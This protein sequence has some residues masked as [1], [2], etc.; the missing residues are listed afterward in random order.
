MR[1]RNLDSN[2]DWTFGKGN[3]N[4]AINKDAVKLNVKTRL[5]EWLND[6]FFAQ[7]KG[8]DY[9]NRLGDKGQE[10][11][12]EQDIRTIIVQTDGVSRLE[13]FSFEVSGRDFSAQYK[14]ITIYDDTFED[15]LEN[16]G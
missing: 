6:C 12:L 11:L 14:I 10:D 4:Y 3:Q 5:Q 8:I 15:F 2:G 1:F 7:D 13:A 9:L 16:V